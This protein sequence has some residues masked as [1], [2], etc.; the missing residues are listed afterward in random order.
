MTATGAVLHVTPL[1]AGRYEVP[2]G[3]ICRG[4]ARHHVVTISADA[5]RCDCPAGGFHRPCRHVE[6]VTAYL[7][8]APLERAIAA[9]PGLTDRDVPPSEDSA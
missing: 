9:G 3:G 6:A 5:V 4:S 1:G 8:L 2:C 7:Q